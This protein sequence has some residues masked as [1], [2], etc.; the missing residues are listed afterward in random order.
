LPEWQAD[1]AIEWRGNSSNSIVF[2]LTW[3][4]SVCPREGEDLLAASY[5]GGEGADRKAVGGG[6]LI[7]QLL[8]NRSKCEQAKE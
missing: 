3:L 8:T 5:L 6:R 2:P 4:P 7:I 1:T